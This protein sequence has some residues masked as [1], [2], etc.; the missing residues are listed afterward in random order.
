M[1]F[2]TRFAPSPTGEL[3]LG[4]AYSA[5]MA[6]ESAKRQNGRFILRIEDTDMGRCR[7][8]F[9]QGIYEDLAW[10]GIEWEK[11]I[12]IQSQHF[13]EYQAII[14]RLAKMGVLYRCFKTRKEMEEAALSAPHGFRDG[15]DGIKIETRVSKAEE[16]MRLLRGDEF[17]LRLSCKAALELIGNDPLFFEDEFHGKVLVD[18]FLNGDIII[19]R[20]DS[21]A[22]YHLCAV[23]DDALQGITNIIRGEDLLIATHIQVVLQ[24]LLGLPTPKYHHHK[25]LLDENG[26]RFA[27][28]D[29]AVTLK[30]L[31]ES[32]KTPSEIRKIVRLT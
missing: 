31:R 19:A 22:S 20:K 3:H 10:L 26:K 14:D 4:H 7:P 29:K 9:S 15:I 5:L 30:S 27:K 13:E 21:K 24:K 23:N 2:V 32:G 16:E 1:N 11:P 18:P 8:E 25:L 12:R 17:A 28:R 6:F